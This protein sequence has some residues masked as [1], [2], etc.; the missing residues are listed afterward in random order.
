M[1]K[2]TTKQKH[3]N[4]TTH[5]AYINPIRMSKGLKSETRALIKSIDLNQQTKQTTNDRMNRISFSRPFV[6]L[7][8]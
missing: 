6:Q 8:D 5:S 2:S 1:R 3:K 7:E 4:E